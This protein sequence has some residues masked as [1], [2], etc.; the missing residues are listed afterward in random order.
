MSQQTAQYPTI[1]SSL[2]YPVLG[3]TGEAGEVAEKVKKIFRDQG[4]VITNADRDALKKEL[5]DTL[6]Y[7]AQIATELGIPLADVAT[8]NIKKLSSRRERGTIGGNGDDR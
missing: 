4:G 8:D 3:L 6:W 7:L 5:G 2:I 1:T